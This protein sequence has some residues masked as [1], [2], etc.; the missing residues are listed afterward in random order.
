L[1]LGCFPVS[2]D[3]IHEDGGDVL[4]LGETGNQF[5]YLRAVFCRG[6]GKFSDSLLDEYFL[7]VPW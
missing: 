3:G 7:L 6:W 2:L 5:S 1:L 4:E